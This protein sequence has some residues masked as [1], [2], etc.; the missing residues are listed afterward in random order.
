LV[1]S[2][3]LLYHYRMLQK[4]T[5][6]PKSLKRAIGQVYTDLK[7]DAPTGNGLGRASGLL[8]IQ[9]QKIGVKKVLRVGSCLCCDGDELRAGC[10]R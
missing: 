5:L 4:L 9:Q 10:Y 1:G 6:S 8:C 7:A 3:V 2:T